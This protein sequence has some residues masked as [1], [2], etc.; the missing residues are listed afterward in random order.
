MV[1]EFITEVVKTLGCS[2]ALCAALAYALT[3]SQYR[4]YILDSVRLLKKTLPELVSSGTLQELTEE[5]V[6]GLIKLIFSSEV[7]DRL[8]F[9]V[10]VY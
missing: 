10:Y 9:Y 5:I 2:P 4:V 3:Q 6:N 7:R 1:A 8:F